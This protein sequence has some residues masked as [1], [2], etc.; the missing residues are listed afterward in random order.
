MSLNRSQKAMSRE[1][2]ERVQPSDRKRFGL[3]EKKKDWIQRT[4]AHQK[5]KNKLR[6]LR[7]NALERNRDEFDY[8][9]V[10]SQVGFDGV[11]REAEPLDEE[12]THV[13]R[14]FND[15]RDITYVRHKL[16]TERKKIEKMRSTLHLTDMPK[17]NTHTIF[18][19]DEEEGKLRWLFD[20]F[21]VEVEKQ[22]HNQ[23]SELTQRLQREKELNVVLQKLEVKKDVGLSRGRSKPQLIARVFSLSLKVR[24]ATRSRVGHGFSISPDEKA[25]NENDSFFDEHNHRQPSAAPILNIREIRLR[26]LQT[27]KNFHFVFGPVKMVAIKKVQRPHLTLEFGDALRDSPAFRQ[28]LDE[29]YNYFMRVQKRY[30]ESV[31]LVDLII[32]QGQNYVS[33]IYNLTVVLNS[34]WSTM[35]VEEP[36]AKQTYRQISDALAQVVH[37]NK[38]L[39]ETTYPALKFDLQLFNDN[40]LSK[41]RETKVRFDQMNLSVNDA[42][43]RRASTSRH[44]TGALVDAQNSLSAIGTLF[45]HTSLDYVA[46]MNMV[47]ARKHHVLLDALYQLYKEYV[48]FFRKGHDFFNEKQ[49]TSIVN[50]A[51]NIAEL[52]EKSRAVE[53]KMQDRHAIVPKNLYE[54]HTGLPADPEIALEGYLFKRS[55]KT[56][57]AWHRRYFMIKGAQF[58]Y[59]KKNGDS[60]QSVVM[61]DDLKFC[62]VRPAP[63]AIER[64]ACFELVSR[65]GSHILQADSE[66]LCQQWI[67]ILQ[68]TIQHLHEDNGRNDN[69][70]SFLK[71]FET[72]NVTTSGNGNKSPLTGRSASHSTSSSST[73]PTGI[74]STATG[75]FGANWLEQV[76]RVPGNRTCADCGNT[77]AKW[78]SLNLGVVICIECS[79]SHRSLGVHISKVRSLTMDDLS[80]DQKQV[81]LELGNFKVNGIYLSGLHE[82]NMADLP[83]QL[84]PTADRTIRERYITAKY[85]EKKFARPLLNKT[86]IN[87]QSTHRS[88]SFHENLVLDAIDSEPSNIDKPN[89]RASV[90]STSSNRMS[91]ANSESRLNDLGAPSVE[92]QTRTAIQHGDLSL[93]M[94]LM[95]S[96]LDINARIGSCHP[97]HLAVENDQVTVMEFLFLNGALVDVLDQDLN[98]PLHI[99]AKKGYLMC[100]YHL[101]KRSA[102]KAMKNVRGETPLDLGMKAENAANIVTLL[103]LHDLRDADQNDGLDSA[104]E[105]FIGDVTANGTM[106]ENSSH[107]SC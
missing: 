95:V 99:A 16:S 33:S 91:L 45:A 52:K 70:T 8:H 81:L 58:V 51:E 89:N 53:K 10:R 19:D 97:L 83:K 105:T 100:V 65:N 75:K 74:P 62:L 79:G 104:V 90:L 72:V 43:S 5:K 71:Q 54:M 1:H 63:S 9:M 87:A 68:V 73:L 41:L 46:Q 26:L 28:D 94:R 18:V 2:R 13:Q 64:S 55:S 11:H 4:R 36:I 22:R 98:T 39:I 57:K 48:V 27:P 56:F 67:H 7:R 82:V 23:Y 92:Q 77:D 24:P 86:F 40:E 3:L 49:D 38:N 60:L 103:R 61:E 93:L 88:S 21:V 101:V 31:R 106:L 25:L 78:T 37:L 12:E 35:E 107:S 6:K 84:T 47:H 69:R 66:P 15:I 85:V 34:L 44:A 30:D 50:A 59:V 102:N 20:S 17:M 29:H 76:K 32:E 42:L 14:V 96:G 80:N